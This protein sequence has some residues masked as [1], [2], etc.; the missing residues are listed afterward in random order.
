MNLIRV[1]PAEEESH[2][3]CS[4]LWTAELV[5]TSTPRGAQGAR[6]PGAAILSGLVDALVASNE[7]LW[8]A[9]VA[10]PW[11]RGLAEG[12]LPEPA[13]VAW[14][15]QCRLFCLLERR[16]LLRLRAS[17]PPP[18]LDAILERLLDDAEREP[19]QL[20]ETLESLGAPV[21]SEP[22]PTCL[23]YGSYVQGC[24]NDGLLEGMAAICA[25]ER[26]YLDTW[27]TLLPAVPPRSRWRGWVENWSAPPFRDLVGGICSSF[28]DLAG[29]PS[30]AGWTRLELIF[31]TVACWELEFWEMC[32]RRRGWSHLQERS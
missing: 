4:R 3:R 13:L 15:Q 8:V 18:Q 6:S 11:V 23:G 28:E 19:R 20:A 2:E 17:A 31:R 22:W 5:D 7:G 25:V 29:T 9:L 32:W 1:M 21:T 26:S 27:T 12:D 10:H 16:A 14:A 30:A 24:A